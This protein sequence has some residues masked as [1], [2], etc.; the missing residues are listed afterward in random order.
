MIV[1]FFN[2]AISKI[3][4][5]INKLK[6]SIKENQFKINNEN[7]TL[8]TFDSRIKKYNTIQKICSKTKL[9]Y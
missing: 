4:Q 3:A 9:Y 7:E 8:I 6:L 1:N 5:N 2:L